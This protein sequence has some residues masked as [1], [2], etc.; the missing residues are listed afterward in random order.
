MIQTYYGFGLKFLSNYPLKGLSEI[1]YEEKP[2]FIDVEVNVTIDREFQTK[3]IYSLHKESDFYVLDLDDV[4]YRID[5][6]SITVIARHEELLYSTFYN[7]PVSIILILNARILLHASAF[8][9]NGQLCAICADKGMGK[10]TLV[11]Y[12]YKQGNPLFVDD[13]LSL[14][15]MN[16]DIY[17]LH[18]ADFIK[19]HEDSCVN[20]GMEDYQSMEKNV[21]NK[22]YVHLETYKHTIQLKKLFFLTNTDQEV[23]VSHVH[24]D[25][26]AK[27]LVFGAVVGVSWF[28]KELITMMKNSEIFEFLCRKVSLLRL[29]MRKN[30]DNMENVYLELGKAAENN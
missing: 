5:R 13:T 6:N 1:P 12:A 18:G 28:D 15:L 2:E 21:N 9:R 27:T 14:V 11:T 3:N 25:M 22:A 29:H 19:L 20:L 26:L 30:W 10:S 24:G 16:G 7:I 23:N 8:I 4:L 17:A